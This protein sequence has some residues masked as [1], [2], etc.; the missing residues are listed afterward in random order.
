MNKL[1]SAE[2]IRLFKSFVFRLCVLFS[3]GFSSYIVLL[4]WWEQKKYYE[5]YAQLDSSYH[6]I[7]NL[8]FNGGLFL[9]FALAVFVGIFVGTEYSDGTIR[10][11]LMVGHTRIN[12]YLSKLIVCAVGTA[13]IYVL[14]FLC[15]LLLGSLLIGKTTLGVATL[16]SFFFISILAAVALTA[17]LLLFSMLIQNKATGCVVC[18]LSTLVL[19]SSSASIYQQL[20][21][22]E[23]YEGYSFIDEETG[24]L[25][26]VEPEKNTR[27]LT[28]A[29]RKVYEFLNN[30]LP[31]SQLYNIGDEVPG[32]PLLSVYDGVLIILVTGI[33]IVIFTKQNL[34]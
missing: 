6:N 7:D 2:F 10:N 14:Y 8:L 4:R 31:T 3:L 12:I 15:T 22:P 13:I 16:L 24:K 28:G 23:Y 17:L 1:L 19:L 26:T 30:V 27:Y 20:T 18:L 33:G 25:I 32:I 21:A 9:I 5:I 34:K 29:K 11:K